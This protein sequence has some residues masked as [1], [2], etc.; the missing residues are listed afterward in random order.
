METDLNVSLQLIVR[1]VWGLMTEEVQ[2]MSAKKRLSIYW[3]IEIWH[4]D[5]NYKVKKKKREKNKIATCMDEFL[6]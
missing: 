6:E 1:K 4:F 5:L 2:H 3:K